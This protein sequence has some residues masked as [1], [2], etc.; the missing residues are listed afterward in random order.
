MEKVCLF[1][2]LPP[3]PCSAFP[4]VT[5]LQLLSGA[6]NRVEL[7]CA[8]H[9]EGRGWEG[10]Q[11]TNHPEQMPKCCPRR[12]DGKG[13]ARPAPQHLPSRPCPLLV[14]YSGKEPVFAGLANPSKQL[15]IS[16][17]AQTGTVSSG[18]HTKSLLCCHLIVNHLNG[19]VNNCALLY[20]LPERSQVLLLHTVGHY[21]HSE[22]V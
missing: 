15:V 9:W 6:G 20:P 3:L 14:L 11:S 12:E 21:G 8:P 7:G 1:S 22:Q 18:S 5:S 4:S 19:D 17:G 13:Q 2:M 16:A 10:T